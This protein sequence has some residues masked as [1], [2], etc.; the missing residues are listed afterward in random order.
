MLPQPRP[1]TH[2]ACLPASTCLLFLASLHPLQTSVPS[3]QT[4]HPSLAGPLECLPLGPARSR[5]G[6]QGPRSG[7]AWF[8]EDARR[9]L[10][11]EAGQC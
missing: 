3:W 5:P 6:S 2:C 9:Q 8:P 7:L 10:T 4:R 1:L 11:A